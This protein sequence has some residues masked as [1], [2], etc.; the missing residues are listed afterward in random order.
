MQ[1]YKFFRARKK[2]GF[3][4]REGILFDAREGVLFD[5]REGAIRLA[6]MRVRV[7]VPTAKNTREEV[8]KVPVNLA[9]FGEL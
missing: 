3:D 6:R 8:A 5:A 2:T 1:R 7:C 9:I 4:A